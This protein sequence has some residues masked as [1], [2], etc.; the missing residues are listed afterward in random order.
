MR[1][2][3]GSFAATTLTWLL[4]S[5]MAQANPTFDLTYLAGTSAEVEA[6]FVQAANVWASS[7]A[8]NVTINL[9]VG[10]GP[11]AAGFLASTA[12]AE[13][14]YPYKVFRNALAADQ[15]SA[16]DVIA[17]NHLPNAPS[18]PIYMN[19]TADNPNGAGSAI[20]YV[21]AKG[22]NNSTVRLTNANAKALG[23]IPVARNLTGCNGDCDGFIEFSNAFAYDFDRADGIAPGSYDLVGLAIHEIGHALG[24]ISGVDI[25][26]ANS[27]APNLLQADQLI[28]VSPLDMFRC[29]AASASAGTTL[30][31]TA[32]SA[33]KSFSLDNCQTALG[34]FS[35]GIARGD[36]YQA[37]HWANGLGLGIMNPT[38]A[39]GEPLTVTALDLAA[40][41]AIGWDLTVPEPGTLAIGTIWILAHLMRAARLPGFGF[42][43]L[44]SGSITT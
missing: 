11:L 13:T 31:F 21:D 5:T 30:D 23:L 27:S 32:G 10:T 28:Y 37:S 41:D 42:K 1:L 7:F 14:S 9:T 43:A 26:D 3:L 24:F 25:L 44:K 2:W 12:S 22:P 19:Y 38:A 4:A 36:G 35:T 16:R 17:V 29:S 33:R 34:A 18:I 20:P 40:F 8:D 39:L 15:T 6:A